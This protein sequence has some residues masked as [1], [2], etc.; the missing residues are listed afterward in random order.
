MVAI[1]CN[2]CNYLILYV[3]MVKLLLSDFYHEML[4]LAVLSVNYLRAL[5]NKVWDANSEWYNI[6]L[7][8]DL[9]SNEL[10]GIRQ[11]EKRPGDCFREVL[12]KWLMKS[13]PRKSQLIE[14]LKQPCVGHEQLAE[15]LCAWVPPAQSDNHKTS[16]ASTRT[17]A[18][19]GA[20]W[21]PYRL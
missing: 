11:E 15:D 6:G 21:F 10:D 20:G 12:K 13:N 2:S 18:L 19:D 5:L 3:L 8:L 17:S 14:A 9:S 7:G 4:G 1:S 16:H